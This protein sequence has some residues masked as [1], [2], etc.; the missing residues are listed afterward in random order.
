MS[1][2]KFDNINIL[3]NIDSAIENWVAKPKRIISYYCDVFF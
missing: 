1:N 3:M 2:E